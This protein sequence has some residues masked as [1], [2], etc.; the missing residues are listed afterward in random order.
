MPPPTRT[1]AE[2]AEFMKSL[3]SEMDMDDSFYN[4]TLTPDPTPIKPKLQSDAS[5]SQ[6]RFEL[7]NA[8]ASTSKTVFPR[9]LPAPAPVTPTRKSNSDVTVGKKVLSPREVDMEALLDG[10]EDWDWSD[11]NTD[12]NSPVKKKAA[13]PLP[14][15]PKYTS[16]THLRCNVLAVSEPVVHLTVDIGGGR[17]HVA[18]ILHDDWAATDV[19]TGDT[20]N[21]VG[22]LDAN[23][24]PSSIEVTSARNFIVTHPDLLLTPST[25]ANALECRRKPLLSTLIRSTSDI[26]PALVWGNILH[27]VMQTCLSSGRWDDSYVE[28]TTEEAVREKIGD[29]AKIDMSVED[30]LREIKFRA[31]GLHAFGEKYISE[32]PQGV[33]VNTRSKADETLRLGIPQLLDIEE[34]IWSPMWGLKGKIDASVLAVVEHTESRNA[35]LNISAGPTPLEIKTGRPVAGLEHRAQTM[36]YTLLTEERYGA[37]VP[38]GLLFYTQSEE[39]V[40]VTA[41]RTDVRG[42]VGLRNE[43][44]SL[45]SR[46][47]LGADER[48]LPPT[49]DNE[50]ACK[51]CFNLDA[52][53]LYRKA[54]EDVVDTTSP[55]ADIYEQKTGH[56]TPQQASFFKK[57]E[58]LLSMEELDAIR[59]KKELWTL[60]A[61]EREAKGRCFSSMQ[62][63]SS[64]KPETVRSKIHKFTYKLR[65]DGTKSKS[66]LEGYINVGDPITVSVEP[67]LLALARGYVLE[68][69]ET[70]VVVG[71]DHELSLEA[72]STRLTRFRNTASVQTPVFRV[73]KDELSSGMGRMR[74]NLAHL[75]Y[76]DGDVRRLQ[77]I[78]DLK[79]PRFSEIAA[80]LPA[81]LNKHWKHLNANQQMAIQR[82]LAADDY[83]LILG[84]P[85][86]GKTTVIAALIRILVGIGKTVLLSSYTHSAVDNIVLKLKGNVDF[87]ILRIGNEDKVHPDAREFTLASRRTPTTV[88]QLEHQIMTPPVVAT[89]CLSVD[90]ALFSRRK[91]DYCIV[92][93]ASQI[94]LPTCLGPLRFAEKF[95]LVGD[96]HQL[97]PLV[98]NPQA[99]KGGLDVSLFRRLSEGHPEAVINMAHQYRMNEDIMTVSNR[100]VYKDQLQCG[101]EE[102]AK[103]S[104]SLPN[105]HFLDGLHAEKPCHSQGCW[106]ERLLDESCKAVFVDTDLVPAHDSRVGDLVQNPVEAQLVHQTVEALLRSGVPAEEIGLI[107]VYRQ[108][109]KLLG[110]LLSDRKELEFLTA[111]RSQGRDKD[112]IVISMV[113]SNDT[114]YVGDLIRDWR[115]MNVSFTRAR[116][117]LII[118]GSRRTLQS[119]PLLKEF[120]CLMEEK[121]WILTL[122]E[123]AAT[124]H[125][126]AFGSVTATKRTAEVPLAKENPSSERS[127]KR[128]KVKDATLRGRPIL[129]DLVNEAAG[130]D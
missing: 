93:E 61:E 36:L 106:L 119:T 88:E 103:R 23:N 30:A 128:I 15:S 116:S 58:A 39:V 65:C 122:P 26:T 46:R 4:V 72:I 51:R 34:D 67:N 87:G 99:R 125:T 86:T 1:A 25:L 64:Y 123:N 75:F 74:D 117:K 77:L 7:P 52:C 96:H 130:F 11:M 38:S 5:Q 111:D 110:S 53:M 57:W 126:W 20:V 50:R 45:M 100:L 109:L 104:L 115:R 69:N 127:P 112:C 2:E 78:V 98:K 6:R 89:T 41:T 62:M 92:D 121:E 18:V 83:A 90:H 42:L 73:D 79:T 16:P 48:F 118:F 102:V 47:Q 29:I 32:K 91:F 10:A 120:F 12:F 124:F 97:P 49:I 80:A 13:V 68:L 82:V 19:R 35:P 70:S 27:E 113:R 31:K 9:A 59:L 76:A 40:Q 33:M 28:T 43:M 94:T 55:I 22:T 3:M 71:V 24:P 107:S 37:E 84:M 14:P 44:A 81:H 54:V 114:G 21:I 8:I 85:G 95:V 60:G 63:D 108:Q 66:L 129:Q 56:I 101:S 105:R 17:A